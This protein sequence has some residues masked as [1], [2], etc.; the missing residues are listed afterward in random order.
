M[1]NSN[2]YI[3]DKYLPKD[4]NNIS[5]KNLKAVAPLAINLHVVTDNLEEKHGFILF[6]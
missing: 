2:I 3:E 1:F 5:E 4:T 6:L